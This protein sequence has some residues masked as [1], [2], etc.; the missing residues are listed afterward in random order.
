[1]PIWTAEKITADAAQKMQIGAGLLL[2]SFDVNNPMEPANSEIIC[3]TTGDFSITCV[4]ETSD[5][6]EDVNNAPTNT[7]EGKRIDGWTC[8]LSVESLT[9]TPEALKFALGAADISDDS[10]GG[11][12][13]R[14]QYK[15]ADFASL[16]WVGDMLGDEDKLFVVAM[17]NA[18]STG[19][20]SITTTN[21]GKGRMALDIT[22][23]VSTANQDKMPMAFYV[24]TKTSTAGS[25]D[26]ATFDI[27]GAD[28]DEP[29]NPSATRYFGDASSISVTVSATA[30]DESA[31]VT[32]KADGTTIDSGN[33][34]T[35]DNG[36]NLF[37]VTVT[38]GGHS[39][40]YTAVIIYNS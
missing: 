27:D 32:I 10:L 4:P 17:D 30:K 40:V 3:D 34:V 29:F 26:L 22:P 14:K 2:N 25:T 6:F 38:N 20:I 13:P 24:V 33:T 15:S 9:F 21:K 1:M 28:F 8:G 5:I 31:T 35:L 7:K 36:A 39:K 18:V 11:V 16:Y 12:N 19:G 37:T 23:H